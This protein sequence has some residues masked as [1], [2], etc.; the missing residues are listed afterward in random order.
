MNADRTRCSF[1]G[2]H[3]IHCFLFARVQAWEL[4]V[5]NPTLPPV[6]EDTLSHGPHLTWV[7]NKSTAPLRDLKCLT[8]EGNLIF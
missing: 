7:K 1:P 5:N 3:A 4:N 2:P 8:P 6:T